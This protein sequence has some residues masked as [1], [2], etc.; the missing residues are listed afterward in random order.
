MDA[1]LV[2]QSHGGG[3]SW[4]N[5]T[6]IGYNLYHYDIVEAMRH[7]RLYYTSILYIHYV[8]KILTM[9]WMAIWMHP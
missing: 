6:H 2:H 1:T 5:Q 7:F 8:F 9:Q 3:L 4:L